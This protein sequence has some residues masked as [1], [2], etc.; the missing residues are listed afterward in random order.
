MTSRKKPGLAFWATVVV[1]V[2]LLLYPLSFGPACWL[3]ANDSLSY[4]QF[5]YAYRPLVDLAVNGP[6]IVHGPLRL[7]VTLCHGDNGLL[8]AQ[9]LGMSR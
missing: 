1:A 9:I 5:D 3:F 2:V 4:H 7:W 8:L 6:S